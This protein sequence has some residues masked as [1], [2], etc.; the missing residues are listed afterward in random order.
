MF[1]IACISIAI[2]LAVGANVGASDINYADFSETSNLTFVASAT[3]FNNRLRV[4]GTGNNN[5]GAVWTMQKHGVANGFLTSYT[6]TIGEFAQPPGSDVLDFVVQNFASDTNTSNTNNLVISLD[7]FQNPWDTSNWHFDVGS[8]DVDS[9]ATVLAEN[10][11]IA[12]GK[13]S[14]LHQIDIAYDSVNT[15]LKVYFDST[16]YVNV[17]LDLSSSLDLDNGSA[18]VGFRATSGAFAETHDVHSWTFESVPEPSTFILAAI[19]LA[20]LM[21]CKMRQRSP[22]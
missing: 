22:A 1:R 12:G 19:G 14:N 16:L 20:L 18:W 17:S 9:L 7:T 10:V 11:T 15:D 3:T 2:M 8:R 6:F 5:S 21:A 4:N 13:N